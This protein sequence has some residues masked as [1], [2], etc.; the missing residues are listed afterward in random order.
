VAKFV[1]FFA[2]FNIA[3]QKKK[4]VSRDIKLARPAGFSL[5]PGP[6]SAAHASASSFRMGAT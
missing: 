6:V 5:R 4:K 1:D 3:S 2:T